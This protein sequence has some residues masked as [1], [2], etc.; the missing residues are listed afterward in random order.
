MHL[1]QVTSL[2]AASDM[3]ETKIIYEVVFSPPSY[4]TKHDKEQFGETHTDFPNH[5]R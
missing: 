5:K 1:K 2:I 4:F 3:T